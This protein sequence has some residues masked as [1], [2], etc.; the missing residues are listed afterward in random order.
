MITIPFSEMLFALLK[1]S[2]LPAVVLP[3]APVFPVIVPP[4]P[5]SGLVPASGPSDPVTVQP[6]GTGV[7]EADAE[8][9][10]GAGAMLLNVNPAAPMVTLLTFSA[11]PLVELRSL[12]APVAVTV[13]L[14]VRLSAVPPVTVTSKSLSA[15]VPTFAPLM[16]DPLVL[17]DV[18]TADHV[19]RR[20][21]H[22]G[23]GGQRQRRPRAADRRPRRRPRGRRDSHQRV[24]RGAGRALTHQ[25]FVGVQRESTA[26]VPE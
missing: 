4:E 8:I 17:I 20:E 3:S 26:T 13:P 21:R 1:N 22:G 14:A 7:D 12:S 10:A 9:G 25:P 16:P 2:P 11:V 15:R 6:T 18:D 23:T 24:E 5:R 19:A